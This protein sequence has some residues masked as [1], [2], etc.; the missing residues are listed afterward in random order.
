MIGDKATTY[1]INVQI[2]PQTTLSFVVLHVVHRAT[3]S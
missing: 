1:T 3:Y 2:R